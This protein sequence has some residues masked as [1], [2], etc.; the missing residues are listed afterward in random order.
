[1]DGTLFEMTD[2][3]QARTPPQTPSSTSSTP[4]L[5]EGEAFKFP[6]VEN[7]T[8]LRLADGKYAIYSHLRKTEGVFAALLK[9]FSLSKEAKS[10][11]GRA[12]T[13]ASKETKVEAILISKAFE[14][15][16][17]LPS[18]QSAISLFSSEL[19]K[20]QQEFVQIFPE[21]FNQGLIQTEA[22]KLFIQ[23]AERQALS[24]SKI[25]QIAAEFQEKGIQITKGDLIK[26]YTS[27]LTCQENTHKALISIEQKIL[28]LEGD[29]YK[30]REKTLA[31]IEAISEEMTSLETAYKQTASKVELL[32]RKFQRDEDSFTEEDE[33]A[34]TRLSERQNALYTEL[35]V[36]IERY[37]TETSYAKY[38]D[39]YVVSIKGKTPMI[40]QLKEEFK[41]LLSPFIEA[42]EV[43][44]SPPT[45]IEAKMFAMKT[46][47]RTANPTIGPNL[48]AF[49]PFNQLLDNLLEA[50][51][52]KHAIT[53]SRI[54]YELVEYASPN[55]SYPNAL[56]A[57]NAYSE[58]GQTAKEVFLTF[59]QNPQSPP[60][61]LIINAIKSLKRQ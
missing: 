11:L 17:E 41:D 7:V 39:A 6:P 34:F 37:D 36:T 28:L 4:S 30:L 53:A 59:F 3:S 52:T 46:A 2:M 33:A 12:S 25:T 10:L 42:R 15:A 45:R 40:E 21:G 51:K 16:K 22:K 57:L 50:I 61:S 49:R 27:D 35:S 47:V 23:H 5:Y 18:L 54:Y 38:L 44:S 13:T 55:P 29:T 1:M 20:Q 8:N 14:A 19:S 60:N 9:T 32:M 58:G 31:K 56:E 24:D 48:P 26:S 43:K